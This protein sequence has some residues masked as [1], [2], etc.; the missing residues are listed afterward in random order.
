MDNSIIL[1]VRSEASRR[2]SVAKLIDSIALSLRNECAYY[3]VPGYGHEKD[4]MVRRGFGT[5]YPDV[6]VCREPN[7]ASA[8]CLFVIWPFSSTRQSQEPTQHG[9]YVT[10]II[11]GPNAPCPLTYRRTNLHSG[12]GIRT[13]VTVRKLCFVAHHCL[14][15]GARVLHSRFARL[16]QSDGIVF[17]CWGWIEFKSILMLA[18]GLS[19]VERQATIPT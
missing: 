4:N 9:L 3:E 11:D 1:I 13:T 16:R 10:K 18:H 6:A 12:R 17:I 14:K 5:T 2:A 7:R 8:K 15:Q 19:D